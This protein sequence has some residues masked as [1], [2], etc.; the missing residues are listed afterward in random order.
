MNTDKTL[1]EMAKP[2]VEA[3]LPGVPVSAS[4]L[5]PNI[6]PALLP[7]VY[8]TQSVKA[9][10]TG[11]G[12]LSGFVDVR[13]IRGPLYRQ[14]DHEAIV[15]A[16]S[17]AGCAVRANGSARSG[18]GYYEVDTMRV[19]VEHGHTVTPLIASAPTEAIA[20][21]LAQNVAFALAATTQ[22]VY[23][24]LRMVAGGAY[25]SST[26]TVRPNSGKIVTSTT[27]TAGSRQTDVSVSLTYW[28][29]GQRVLNGSMGGR[30]RELM[31]SY[32]GI[33]SSGLGICQSAKVESTDSP[34]YS[35]LTNVVVLLSFVSRER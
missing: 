17:L 33:F 35:G 18:G 10:T 28:T 27:D 12:T 6:D 31:E 23:E 25:V 21:R 26:A 16:A 9:T 2:W 4:F 14:L 13:Y 19:N 24:S 3:T 5:V 1:A 34:D 8:I 20:N 29:H 30:L 11:G 32:A 7:V 22:P 15:H